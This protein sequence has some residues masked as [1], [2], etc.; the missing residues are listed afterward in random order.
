MNPYRSTLMLGSCH[1][2]SDILTSRTRKIVFPIVIAS[3][4]VKLLEGRLKQ[5]LDAFLSDRLFSGQMGFVPLNRITVNQCRMI[6]RI[7][8]RT[9]RQ[10]N[11]QH[12]YGLFIDWAS[13][14]NW[15][16]RILLKRGRMRRKARQILIGGSRRIRVLK[17]SILSL[18]MESLAIFL[19]QI[20]LVFFRTLGQLFFLWVSM[21]RASYLI[22][23]FWSLNFLFKACQASSWFLPIKGQGSNLFSDFFFRERGS[24]IFGSGPVT[25]GS[26]GPKILT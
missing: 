18:A 11:G 9:Q 10:M 12:A 8:L 13:F 17:L 6:D 7:K 20:G 25:F 3:P 23:G 1:S 22:E 15:M 24:W 5:K 14:W 21:S 4:L 19:I 2:I 16:K 26:I